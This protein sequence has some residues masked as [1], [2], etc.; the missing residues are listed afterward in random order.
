MKKV[1]VTVILTFILTALLAEKNYSI[2]GVNEF[3]FI[4]RKMTEN[5]E[6]TFE[7]MFFYLYF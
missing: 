2:S 7:G 5:Y 3:E 1:L 6:D 4:Y